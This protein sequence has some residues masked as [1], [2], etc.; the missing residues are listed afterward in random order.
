MLLIAITGNKGS[1][2]ST[3]LAQLAAWY[4]AEKRPVDG[5]VAEAGDRPNAGKGAQT[6][7]LRWVATGELS[8]FASRVEAPGGIPYVLEEATQATTLAWAE[9]LPS[10]SEL[11]V[12]DEFGLL[13]AEGHGHMA[14]WPA[15]LAADPQVVAMTVRSGVEDA[16]AE[17]L[18]RNFDLVVAS[19]APEAWETLRKACLAHRDWTRVGL[20][21]AA[22]GALEM[23][24]GAALHGGKLPFRGLVMASAQ[25]SVMTWAASGLGARG[26]VVW[27]PFIAAGLKALSPAGNR[28][29]PMLAITLQGLLY[30]GTIRLLGWNRASVAVASALVGAWAAAQGLVLQYLLVGQELLRAY[31][32]V[33]EQATR[34][35]GLSPP[36]IATAIGAWIGLWALVAGTVGALT[37]GRTRHAKSEDGQVALRLDDWRARWGAGM[38]SLSRES[39]KP[40]WGAALGSG[41]RDLLRPTFWV[42]LLLVVGI[43][44]AAG[45]P[46]EAAFWVVARAATIGMLLFTAV[47]FLDVQGAVRALRRRGHWGPAIAL[48]RAIETLSTPPANRRS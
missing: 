42:P 19:D 16:V 28:L 37:F 48:S 47:R 34:F 6:Y 46:W 7:S 12:L 35:I 23:S 5:F 15:I 4:R 11:V 41:A 9:A 2:K 8:L 13:E 18:G 45:S 25:A 36:A 33:V 10:T 26:R 40:T 17:R 39:G 22:S 1:G 44:L 21:G 3:L 20:H 38:P 43:I 14:L 29:R 27:V 24:L 30:A 31:A 32:W